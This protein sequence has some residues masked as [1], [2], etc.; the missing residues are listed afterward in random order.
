MTDKPPPASDKPAPVTDK[1]PP[2]SDKP[3]QVT[4]KPPADKPPEGEKPAP[5]EV[6]ILHH[7]PEP[8][9]NGGNLT[10][11]QQDKVQ[12]ELNE[13]TQKMQDLRSKLPPEYE[14]HGWVW[15]FLRK[16]A[17]EKLGAR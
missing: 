7:A 8:K 9:A 1:P 4:D 16:P 11:E 13:V 5:G 17:S 15:L 3:P 10:K 6:L 12:K 14:N 2:A